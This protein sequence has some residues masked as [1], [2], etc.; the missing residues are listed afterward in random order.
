ML[1]ASVEYGANGHNI[2]DHERHDI[3]RDDYDDVRIFAQ[4][5]NIECN[6]LALNATS[7]PMLINESAIAARIVD[8][9]LVH[10]S[11]AS[12]T[13]VLTD[14]AGYG[15]CVRWCLQFLVHHSNPATEWQ[16]MIACKSPGLSRGGKIVSQGTGENE[17]S[18]N[19][20]ESNDTTTPDSLTEHPDVWVPAC[21]VQGCLYV[22]DHEHIA[23][24]EDDSQGS[25]HEIGP[26]HCPRHR[27]PSILDL[28]GHVCSRIRA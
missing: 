1:D 28:F 19:G 11:H 7:D 8:T 18:R 22:G 15:D 27:S 26:D 10:V 5:R 21:I 25:V 24:K 14:Q 6:I 9:R 2:G 3:E 4:L 20:V 23:Y 16:T 13:Y 17:H 12:R